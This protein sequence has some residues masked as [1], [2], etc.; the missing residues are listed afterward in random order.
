M[1]IRR[2]EV[3]WETYAFELSPFNTIVPGSYDGVTR[4]TVTFDTWILENEHL[5]VTLLPEYGGRILSIVSKATGHEQLYQNP[6][7]VPYQ[8]D[9]GVF[10]Y[11]WL[12][13]YGGIFPTFPEPEHGK[14]W[15][16]PWE[17]EIVEESDD[18]VT[19]AM[20]FT[21]D[22]VVP[23]V[24]SQYLSRASGLEVTFTITLRAGR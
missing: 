7:G 11:N 9:T 21:D 13:V 22:Q 16:L 8:I 18:A 23:F 1:G 17:F 2:S 14:T 3:T 12:M 6:V 24:P 15:F 5:E 10:Y 20:S 4:T 19:V